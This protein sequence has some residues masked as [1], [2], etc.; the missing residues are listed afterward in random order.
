MFHLGVVFADADFALIKG[1]PTAY[2]QAGESGQDIV[3]HFCPT[4][5]SGIYNEP[6]MIPGIVVV[7]GGSLDQLPP[8]GPS[9]MLYARSK[10]GWLELTSLEQSFEGARA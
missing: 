9:Y 1:A 2:A 6:K 4:C 8:S 7:R 5:G 10:P 3:R